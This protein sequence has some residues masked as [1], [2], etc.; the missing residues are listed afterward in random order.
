MP[1][2]IKQIQFSVEKNKI[3]G[4][5]L[6]R[7]TLKE[8]KKPLLEDELYNWF[9]DQKEQGELPSQNDLKQKAME[10]NQSS[11][12]ELWHPTKGFVNSARQLFGLL[13]KS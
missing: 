7:K 3:I 6:G 10:I 9:I 1:S 2:N 8:G 12:D 11:S 13:M 5:K 4:V